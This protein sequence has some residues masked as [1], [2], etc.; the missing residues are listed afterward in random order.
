MPLRNAV[1]EALDQVLVLIELSKDHYND[2]P[3]S[4]LSPIGK[5]VRHIV[6]HLWAFQKGIDTGCI[7]YN[8]RH[9][10]SVLE[11]DPLL[12]I[13]ALEAFVQWL[14]CQWLHCTA[15]PDQRIAVISEISVVGCEVAEVTS[16]LERELTYLIN[17]TLHHVAYA[18]LLA[19]N[20]GLKASERLGIA[21][22][23]A[24][25]LRCQGSA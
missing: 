12:A 17:H 14:H 3:E 4:A 11:R 18:G 19:R 24:T 23:T 13:E 22:A 21:P 5:H 2:I 1:C 20:L 16:S 10:N 25:Y 9:R 6:D 8:L 15:L 7:D